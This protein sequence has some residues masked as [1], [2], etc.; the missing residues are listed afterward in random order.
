MFVF[1]NLVLTLFLL[2]LSTYPAYLFNSTLAENYD[3][4]MGWLGPAQRKIDRFR[5]RRGTFPMPVVLGASG[6]AGAL[7]FGLLDPN[8]GFNMPSFALLL[9]LFASVVI[10]S[11]VYDVA[12]ARYMHHHFGIGSN[13]RGYP[14]GLVVAA[15]LVLLSRAAHFTPGYLFGVFTALGFASQVDKRK[16]GKGVAVAALWLLGVAT[17]SWFLWVPVADAASEPDADFVVLFLDATL[18]T[19]WV[20]GI[21]SVV[22]GLMP[23]RFLDGEKAKSWSFAGWAAIYGLGMFAFVHSMIRPGAKVDG[24]SFW[25]AIVLFASFTVFAVVFWAFFRFRTPRPT[26]PAPPADGPEGKELVDA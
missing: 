13:L 9:G 6:V 16:D 22:F 18:A 4:V 19:V 23:L 20:V 21:Q 7:L 3:G 11:G 17:L 14:A 15:V 26:D 1:E 8:L 24:D 12:R 5:A 25:T 10:V 2:L